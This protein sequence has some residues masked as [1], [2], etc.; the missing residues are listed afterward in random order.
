MRGR[1]R[2][3][4]LDVLDALG[5]LQ[6]GVDQ[7]R[8]ADLVLGFELGQQLVEIVDVPRA[9][10]LGQHDDVELFAGRGND[11]ENVIEH[12]GRVEAIDARPQAGCAEVYCPCHLR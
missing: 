9:F 5:G 2:G 3:D 1:G 6:N 12:P 11:F 8:L 4:R 10:D 7:D